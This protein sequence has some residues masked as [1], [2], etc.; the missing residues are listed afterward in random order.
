MM[1]KLGKPF[2]CIYY[3]TTF[4]TNMGH[5]MEAISLVPMET[6]VTVKIDFIPFKI[7]KN[8]KEE[9]CEDVYLQSISLDLI[10]FEK[11]KTG[12]NLPICSLNDI[13]LSRWI[14]IDKFL[15]NLIDNNNTNNDDIIFVYH[16]VMEYLHMILC[17]ISEGKRSCIKVLSDELVIHLFYLNAHHIL[18]QG[19][20]KKELFSK[21]DNNIYNIH[22]DYIQL[23][24]N[25]LLQLPQTF[26]YF[27]YDQNDVQKEE[28]LYELIIFSYVLTQN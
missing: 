28:S 23:L 9:D 24:Y 27:K 11:I 19:K 1:Y 4:G 6:W 16:E 22:C 2:L 18:D 20:S 21:M 12:G 14:T 15:K 8:H 13:E 26:E 5:C 3:R 17:F 7:I 25:Y 10:K